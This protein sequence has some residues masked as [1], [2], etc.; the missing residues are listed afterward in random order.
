LL[1]YVD[2]IALLK[3]GYGDFIPVSAA[4]QVWCMICIIMA[5]SNLAHIQFSFFLIAKSDPKSGMYRDASKL[6]KHYCKSN[7][8]LD[9]EPS[10]QKYLKMKFVET[11]KSDEDVIGSFPLAVKAKILSHV[12]KDVFAQHPLFL[13]V[14]P[15]YLEEFIT[16]GKVEV[17]VSGTKLVEQGVIPARFYVLLAGKVR[18]GSFSEKSLLDSFGNTLEGEDA[19]NWEPHGAIQGMIS[20]VGFLT[21]TPQ[22]YTVEAWST[23]RTLTLT[24]TAFDELSE[25]FPV[26]AKKLYT[27]LL[28]RLRR[29]VQLLNLATQEGQSR[30][31]R[32]KGLDAEFWLPKHRKAIDSVRM[33]ISRYG[34]KRTAGFL[35]KAFSGD[36]PGI[37]RAISEGFDINS[38]NYDGRTALIIAAARGFSPIVKAL[39]EAGAKVDQLDSRSHSALLEAVIFGHE[40][41]M[42]LLMKCG[43]TLSTPPLKQASVLCMAT[44]EGD[45]ALVE[46]LLEAGVSPN[47]LDYGGRTALDIAVSLGNLPAV[48]LLAS[49]GGI[50][51]ANGRWAES[52]HDNAALMKRKVDMYHAL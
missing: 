50:E 23:C 35:Q 38:S 42:K 40:T 4:E 9:L 28:V 13:G 36:L 30:A 31:E 3:V 1:D 11:E 51:N 12:Y 24:R 22:T 26:A 7:S 46:R 19:G 29:E 14:D 17:F 16:R 20:D 37:Q 41:T 43:A 8:L 44:Y 33:S 52:K 2:A 32:I 18:S 45:L 6:I 27:N 15:S 21:R 48:K 5:I 49:Y 25:K 47:V 34:N 10:M 39:I